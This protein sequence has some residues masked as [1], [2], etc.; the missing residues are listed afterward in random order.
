MNEAL[1][2]RL[3]ESA[4]QLFG[5][6]LD[7]DPASLGMAVEHMLKA[8]LLAS[9]PALLLTKESFDGSGRL[10]EALRWL[11][12]DLAVPPKRVYTVGASEAVKRAVAIWPELNADDLVQIAEARNDVAHLGVQAPTADD[13]TAMLNSFIVAA[14]SLLPIQGQTLKWMFGKHWRSLRLRVPLI[15]AALKA[16]FEARIV[17]ISAEPSG[18]VSPTVERDRIAILCPTCGMLGLLTGDKVAVSAGFGRPALDAH[19]FGDERDENDDDE[20]DEEDFSWESSQ[21]SSFAFRV[22]GFECKRCGFG[23][24]TDFE[25]DHLRLD[26]WYRLRSMTDK[27][28]EIYNDP[29]YH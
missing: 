29:H 23:F 6:S 10:V 27:E 2:Q 9:D 12:G 28:Y 20:E 15:D 16:E 7:G 11:R 18:A 1:L 17:A 8:A 14:V 25:C 5:G 22:S 19:S 21:L 4:R 24:D 3:S 13:F 26:E